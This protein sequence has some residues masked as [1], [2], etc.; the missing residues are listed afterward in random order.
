MDIV[1]LTNKSLMYS[2]VQSL[3][4][5]DE[6]LA[7]SAAIQ[8]STRVNV[9]KATFK[10]CEGDVIQ[11]LVWAS[12]FE[13]EPDKDELYAVAWSGLEDCNILGVEPDS[14]EVETF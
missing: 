9:H 3:I 8:H 14:V 5:M 11:E 4:T 12:D 6:L 7:C 10:D 13:E 2:F 1:K